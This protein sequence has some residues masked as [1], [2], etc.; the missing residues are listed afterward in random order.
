MN[1]IAAIL[2]AIFFSTNEVPCEIEGVVT[3]HRRS[4]PYFFI[5]DSTG[6]PWRV[7]V[8]DAKPKVT[9]GDRVLV[10][11]VKP[12]HCAT[13]RIERAVYEKTGVGRPPI[14]LEMTVDEMYAVES[15][16][17][18]YFRSWFGKVIAVSGP[19]IDIN[20]RETYTQVL[21]GTKR[22]NVQVVVPLNW[23]DSM[24][25]GM[26]IG[27]LIRARGVGVYS[28]LPS[29]HNG[30][31]TGICDFSVLASRIDDFHVLAVAPFWSV[32]RIA[33]AAVALVVLAL[34]PFLWV[35][36]RRRLESIAADGARRERL[37]LTGEL[38][39]NFQQL[40]A[41]CMFLLGAAQG[42]VRSGDAEK[43]GE[44]LERLRASLNHTQTTLRGALWGLTE[45]AEGPGAFTE[46]FKYAAGRMPQWE[47]KVRFTIRGRERAVARKCSGA[48]LLILLEA[49]GNALKHG[50]ASEVNVIV[51]FAEDALIFGVNDNG[52]GFVA[53]GS[54][55]AGHLGLDNMRKHAEGLGGSFRLS[56]VPGSGTSV[57]VR[58]PGV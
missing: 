3:A 26:S 13:P 15:G 49:V 35:Q 42:K 1:L 41:G 46:L 12:K 11:G 6:D 7:A 51:D 23:N 8:V 21:I 31:V 24:P 55:A 58:L 57:V 37:R 2:S 10:K 39:D 36:R 19:V 20:R 38:H 32:S 9:V 33:F 28:Q 16:G 22:K 40:L 44:L 54:S 17:E 47:G 50:G 43:A 29:S 27:S 56:S 30:E 52:C 34:L 25:N 4:D 53:Q 45:E 18:E 48:L 5:V 14:T